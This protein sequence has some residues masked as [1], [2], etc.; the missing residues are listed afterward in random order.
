MDRNGSEVVGEDS[1]PGMWND[2][3]KDP[4]MGKFGK[5]MGLASRVHWKKQQKIKWEKWAGT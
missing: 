1:F 2:T 3:N 5:Y 4:V